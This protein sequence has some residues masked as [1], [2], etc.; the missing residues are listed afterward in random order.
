MVDEMQIKSHS[1]HVVQHSRFNMVLPEE[2]EEVVE[3]FIES[4][5]RTHVQQNGIPSHWSLEVRKVLDE[6]LPG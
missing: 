4:K 6:K 1:V 3:W 5:S 2:Q